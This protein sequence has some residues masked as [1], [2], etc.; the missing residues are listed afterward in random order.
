MD[1]RCARVRD[2]FGQHADD[3]VESAANPRYGPRAAR[4]KTVVNTVVGGRH[5]SAILRQHVERRVCVRCDEVAAADRSQQ[6]AHSIRIVEGDR[7]SRP[8]G[9]ARLNGRIA[10]HAAAASQ[11]SGEPSGRRGDGPI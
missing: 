1:E 11:P 3:R 6:R 7:I 10:R 9:V 2:G 4:C 5:P 8:F